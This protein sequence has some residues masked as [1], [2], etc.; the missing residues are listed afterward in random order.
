M[1]K[2][3]LIFFL[4]F[5]VMKSSLVFSETIRYISINDIMN[6]SKAGLDIIS[7]LKKKNKILS[8]SFKNQEAKFKKNEAIIINQKNILE[9]T[10]LE[11]KVKLLRKEIILYN[12]NK[13]IKLKNLEKEKI[14]AQTK[15][16][17]YINTI[18]IDYMEKNS[19]SFILKK[20]SVFVGK[21]EL[22]ITSEILLEID[23]KITKI[24]I[25]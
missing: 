23:N 6:Q 19:I 25:E 11:N 18:M 20:E 16:I 10:E 1:L 13:T 7:Q 9:K 24:N 8:S 21:K 5:F 3:K 17:D 4:I 2:F 14:K 22:D 12:N 15:L